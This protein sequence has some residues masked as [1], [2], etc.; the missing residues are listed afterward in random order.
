V[1][2][3]A[4]ELGVSRPTL[5]ELIERYGLGK[6]DRRLRPR[7]CHGRSR[8]EWTARAGPPPE[9][10]ALLARAASGAAAARFR[11]RYTL[12]LDRWT[13]TPNRFASRA[14]RI[15]V[16]PRPDRRSRRPRVEPQPVRSLAHGFARPPALAGRDV[17]SVRVQLFPRTSRVPVAVA[18][19]DTIADRHGGVVFPTGARAGCGTPRCARRCGKREL[20]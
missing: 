4:A 17:L 14:Q 6:A 7:P 19:H 1:T 8:S 12:I 16:D 20:S 3:T 11:H 10:L 5:Y 9:V 15:V 2:R 18:F 13:P